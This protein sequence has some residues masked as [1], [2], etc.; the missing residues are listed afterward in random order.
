MSDPSRCT[1][2]GHEFFLDGSELGRSEC[3][4][5]G[6]IVFFD[7]SGRGHLLIDSEPLPESASGNTHTLGPPT[8]FTKGQQSSQVSSSKKTAEP[9]DSGKASLKSFLEQAVAG[10]AQPSELSADVGVSPNELLLSLDDMDQGGQGSV[11]PVEFDI[12]KEDPQQGPPNPVG[13]IGGL[14][15]ATADLESLADVAAFGNAELPTASSGALVYNI[16]IEGIDTIELRQEF[17][18]ALE[19]RRLGFDSKA[20][21]RSIIAGRLDLV[22]LNPVKASVLLGRIKNLPITVSWIAEQLIKGK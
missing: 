2:C 14:I 8:A 17:V 13:V 10:G 9:I 5:C 6:E 22:Y 15:S 7:V 1:K 19:D 21:M 16:H 18:H 3:P 12:K 20:V 4:S 11:P